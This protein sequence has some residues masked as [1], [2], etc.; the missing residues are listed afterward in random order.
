LTKMTLLE[1]SNSEKYLNK[2]QHM[3][4]FHGSQIICTKILFKHI[5]FFI[6]MMLFGFCYD[7]QDFRLKL[8]GHLIYFSIKG[9]M[10]FEMHIW[11]LWAY[12][13]DI[14]STSKAMCSV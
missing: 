7:K 13:T 10:V 12:K 5:R 8:F 11:I 6:V 4:S 14:N 9:W 3:N 2:C 1:M